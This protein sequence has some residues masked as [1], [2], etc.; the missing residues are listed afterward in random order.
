MCLSERRSAFQLLSYSVWGKQSCEPGVKKGFLLHCRN[1]SPCLIFRFG[2][3]RLVSTV[4][5]V[6]KFAYAVVDNF[7]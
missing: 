1:T 7:V 2:N 6:R 3:T 5:E 4:Q